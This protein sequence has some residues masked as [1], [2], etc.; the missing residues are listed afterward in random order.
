MKKIT[1]KEVLSGS[2][3][4]LFCSLVFVGVFFNENPSA[5]NKSNPDIEKFRRWMIDLPK[6]DARKI[7]ETA[8]AKEIIRQRLFDIFTEQGVSLIE[9]C[10]SVSVCIRKEKVDYFQSND[11]RFSRSNIMSE[12]VLGD[13]KIK[14]LRKVLLDGKLYFSS[15][16]AL[17]SFDSLIILKSAD[18]RM[19]IAVS[20]HDF[21]HLHKNF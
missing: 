11:D 8:E 10:E 5:Q 9:N 20:I 7:L 18:T 2:A 3:V 21:Y 13:E 6:D 14:E 19:E 12:I 16:D 4:V 1:V 15:L 17:P